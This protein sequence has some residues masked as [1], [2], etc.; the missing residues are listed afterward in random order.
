MSAFGSLWA[1]LVTLVR[2]K[3]EGVYVVSEN[4]SSWSVLPFFSLDQRKEATS[5][6]AIHSARLCQTSRSPNTRHS[7]PFPF[8][9]GIHRCSE[10]TYSIC[11]W[12]REEF[13]ASNSASTI[14]IW[15]RKEQHPG[16]IPY[17]LYHLDHIE[18]VTNTTP[19]TPCHLW[20]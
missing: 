19:T 2:E 16:E 4:V 5:C 9:L 18:I 3:N 10:Y 17:S 15:E 13:T 7:I 12:H 6:A 20:K 11:G 14:I 1:S 8:V